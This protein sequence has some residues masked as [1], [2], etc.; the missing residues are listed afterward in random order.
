MFLCYHESRNTVKVDTLRVSPSETLRER[1]FGGTE[2][3]TLRVSP[4]ETL[5]V[6]LRHALRLRSPLGR[7]TLI[8][9][10]GTL[11]EQGCLTANWTHHVQSS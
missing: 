10:A 6:S 4:S 5:R 9:P 7:E 2:A 1:Q 3:D 11:R 8:R